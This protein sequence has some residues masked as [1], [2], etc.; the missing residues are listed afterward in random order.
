MQLTLNQIINVKIEN[1]SYQVKVV[2]LGT[3]EL[4]FTITGP[5]VQNPD[6]SRTISILA[7]VEWIKAVRN[8]TS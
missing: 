6:K 2:K 3:K 7:F 4:D 5:A 1:E 8:A